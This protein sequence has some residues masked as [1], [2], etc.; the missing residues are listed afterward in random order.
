MRIYV[1]WL[2]LD[3][4]ATYGR[5][6]MRIAI[7]M[8]ACQTGSRYRGIGRY[9]KE[10][11]KALAYELAPSAEHEFHIVVD[12]T[13]TD[14]AMELLQDLDGIIEPARHTRYVYPGPNSPIGFAGD[15]LRPAARAIVRA[16]YKRLAPDIIHVNSLFE[17]SVEHAACLGGLS[18][19]PGTVSSVTLYDL[20]PLRFQSDYLS[21]YNGQVWYREKL[22]WLSKFNLI[23]CI[24][25]SCKRDAVEL[26]GLEPD[27]ITV[28]SA[29]VDASFTPH[30]WP[31][32][33]RE[34]FLRRLGIEDE[35][36]LFTGNADPRKNIA[37]AIRAFA[38]VPRS[39]RQSMQLVLNQVEDEKT[40]RDV[41]RRAGLKQR[42]LVITGHIS[43][44]ELRGLLQNCK[45][46]FFP[47]LY[48][49]FGLPPLEAMACGAACIAGDN[50]SLPEILGR[51]DALFNSSSI[52]DSSDLLT[53]TL[54]DDSFRHDLQQHGLRQ[55]SKFTWERTAK[56]AIDAWTEAYLRSHGPAAGVKPR[57]TQR[58]RL[59]VVTPLPPEKTGIADYADQ[60]APFLE[61]YFQTDYFTTMIG[62]RSR[63][64]IRRVYSWSDLPSRAQQYEHVLYYMGNSPFHS[65]MLE[66]LNQVP[67]TVVMHDLFLSGMLHYL[68]TIGGWHGIFAQEVERSHGRGALS[69]LD[70]PAGVRT[71]V[72][73]FPASRSVLDAA[74][75]VIFH[76][77]SG[78]RMARKHFPS[79]RKG[80]WRFIPM[81]VPF[82]TVAS[83]GD[84]LVT[85]REMGFSDSDFVVVSFGF[86]AATK[87]CHKIIESVLDASQNVRLVFVGENDGGDY[88]QALLSTV[89][90]NSSRIS[91]TGFVTAEDF[92][93]FARIADCAV[94]LRAQSRG[95]S[96]KTVL[97]CLSAGLP[98]VVNNYESFCELPDDVAYKVRAEPEP[99][100]I[101]DAIEHIMQDEDL[102]CRL[103][104]AGQAYIRSVH[105]PVTVAGQFAE[106][107]AS[108]S[109][110]TELE[111]AREL[112]SDLSFAFSGALKDVAHELDATEQALRSG[113]PSLR[114]PRL[115]IDLSEVARV[116]YRTGIHRVVRNLTRELMLGE[117]VTRLRVVPVKH[118]GGNLVDAGDFC[119]NVLGT[120]A[121]G[122]RQDHDFLAGDILLLLDSA[123]SDPAMF[124]ESIRR[125]HDAGGRVGAVVYDL[126]PITHPHF[127][128]DFMPA[129][130]TSWMRYVVRQC[131][132]AICISR[133]VAD[134]LKAW[135]EH[136][137]PTVRDGFRIGFA[138][139]GAD[140][141][142]L[143]ESSA[144]IDEG[145]LEFLGKAPTFIVTGTLEPRKRIDLVLDAFDRAWA[146]GEDIQLA[147]I[148]KSG[149]NVEDLIRTL[150]AHSEQGRRLMWF[151]DLDDCTLQEVYRRARC[152]IQASDVEGFG[153]PVIEAKLHGLPVLLSDIPVFREMHPDDARF[154]VAGDV[155]SLY[156]RIKEPI[157]EPSRRSEVLTWK[158]SAVLFRNLMMEGGWRHVV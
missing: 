119:T 136:E 134:T 12:G 97:D 47:S 72:G 120:P 68:D 31:T 106:I 144:S 24:S 14:H 53:K 23:F 13:Y 77:R 25:E 155:D 48:E 63:S 15:V 125:V 84:R 108:T 2:T 102:R 99:R 60:F 116:D 51:N 112:A 146:D 89:Q 111:V 10:F 79:L 92:E 61:K 4:R 85:R 36:V 49:G 113:M 124:D 62:E 110:T 74:L 115:Y 123:W 118:E 6:A 43:D 65:H 59:A 121:G 32:V 94:Q 73:E 21:D 34:S 33:E 38:R 44:R 75:A 20:I 28:I 56:R 145:V 135:I 41:A 64:G 95:E 132:F 117:Q 93:R 86:L 1:D 142:P 88:G 137:R 90:Q 154:F 42:D 109:G 126:I 5:S 17:G 139:L 150:R 149:W 152:L 141:D 22:Q 78:L 107:I 54:V 7:D 57:R 70:D 100:E 157:P 19:V 8:Q 128:V 46:F 30:D 105:S 39:A 129:V 29:G 52:E 114:E 11:T 101:R 131:D 76:S 58:P 18:Q 104:K 133:T 91:I 69:L 147:I 151:E 138:H 87:L 130:F 67:G 103:S 35:Y 55:A 98:T 81:P 71:A 143:L 40:V 9:S 16:H 50:S 27:R 80:K 148:G 26:I 37:G 45:V 82:G 127:C 140:L 96:S 66:L 158:E 3:E 153:L 83:D 156:R 122:L